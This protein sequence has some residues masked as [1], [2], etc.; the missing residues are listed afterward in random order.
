MSVS[1]ISVLGPLRSLLSRRPALRWLAP[2]ATT[3]AVIGGGLGIGALA[4]AADP[5]LPPRSAAELLVDLQTARLDGMSGTI[6]Q[7]AD[8]G[9]P[10]LPNLGGQGSSELTSLVAGTHTL[11]VWYS[12]PNKARVALLGTLGESDVITNGTDVWIWSSK[13]NKAIHRTLSNG[14]QAAEGGK[15]GMPLPLPS[16]GPA[17]TLGMTPEQVAKLALAAIEPSTEVSTDGSA[18]VAGRDAYE[19][20]LAPRDP[21]ALVASVRLAID[22]TE[23]VPLRVQVYARGFDSP[24]VDI[25]F[26]QV[27][28]ARPDDQQFTFSP[29]PGATVEEDT[30]S[31]GTPGPGTPHE[32]R[33]DG[34]KPDASA[35]PHGDAATGR[36]AVVGS[37]WT[38]VLVARQPQSP[39]KTGAQADGPAAA[40]LTA[41]LESQ[42][43]VSG[44][45]GSGHLLTSKLFSVL[46]TDDGRILVGAVRPDRLYQAAADPAAKP[47]R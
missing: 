47:G 2:V 9:L 15:P 28:F 8:L 39:D 40:S 4:A 43:S 27:S 41:F 23:H 7:R 46:W 32:A 38:S 6:V 22:A 36:P 16:R 18:T 37:G 14:D 33:P 29:P 24:A 5:S 13:E 11:R 42:P 12:G 20:V 35:R 3:L 17:A 31:L 10:A 25:A 44:T 21:A 45:W 30:G 1:R 19:L 26:T 34:A